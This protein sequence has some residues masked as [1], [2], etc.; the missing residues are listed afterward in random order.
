MKRRPKARDIRAERDLEPELTILDGDLV[1]S[2]E[3]C[4][5]VLGGNLDVI[6]EAIPIDNDQDVSDDGDL[7]A[8]KKLCGVSNE[9]GELVLSL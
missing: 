2:C 7:R 6:P 9:T 1:F 8:S 4:L 5:E 3:P